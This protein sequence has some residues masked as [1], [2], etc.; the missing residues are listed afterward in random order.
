MVKNQI[1]SLISQGDLPNALAIMKVYFSEED[2]LHELVDEFQELRKKSEWNNR[3]DWEEKVQ[4]FLEEKKQMDWAAIQSTL[5]ERRPHAVEIDLYFTSDIPLQ[6]FM[7]GQFLLELGDPF[8]AIKAFTRATELDPE[9]PNTWRGLAIAFVLIKEYYKSIQYWKIV[10][11]IQPEDHKTMYNI[12]IA[13][14]DLQ[15]PANAI[16]YFESAH[17][18][19]PLEVDYLVHAGVAYISIG[20]VENAIKTVK[21]LLEIKSEDAQSWLTVGEFFNRIG[22]SDEAEAHFIVALQKAEDSDFQHIVQYRMGYFYMHEKQFEKAVE[23][24][25]KVLAQNPENADAEHY[26]GLTLLFMKAYPESHIHF[27]KAA[28]LDPDN[29]R[30]LYNWSCLFSLEFNKDKALALLQKSI[31]L[32][33]QFSQK[34]LSDADYDWLKSDEDFIKTTQTKE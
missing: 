7:L 11:E 22:N 27:E 9:N 31:A 10:L 16:P 8:R 26:L 15:Q 3:E 29:A 12:G 18:L 32:D 17:A 28:L 13:Y 19:S 14:N 30:I 6:W 33:S 34:A 20:E 1:L 2:E 5:P 4:F 21:K 24:F 25:E 23:N